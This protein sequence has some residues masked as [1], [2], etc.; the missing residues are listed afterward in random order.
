MNGNYVSYAQQ[1]G[2]TSH[3][4]VPTLCLPGIIGAYEI[5]VFAYW[6]WWKEKAFN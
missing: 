6:K 3:A 4:Y 5:S 2:T 1:A